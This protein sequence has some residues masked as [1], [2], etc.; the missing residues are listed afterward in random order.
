MKN[1]LTYFGTYAG[2]VI[3]T[4]SGILVEK[5]NKALKRKRTRTTRTIEE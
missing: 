4:V 1:L 2:Q 3:F 5:I